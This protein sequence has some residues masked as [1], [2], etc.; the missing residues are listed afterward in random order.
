MIHIWTFIIIIWTVFVTIIMGTLAILASF[1]DS[2]GNTS[3]SIARAWARSILAVSRIKVT[4]DGFSNIDP[5][6]SYI[7]MSNHQ[8]N[9]DI[10]VLL[11]YL[12]VQFRWLA[13]AELF[14]IPLFGRAMQGAGYISIDRSNRRLAIE[15]LKEAGKSIQKGSSVMIFPEGTRSID[16]NIREFKKGGFIL[17][18]EAGVPIIPVIIH[19]TWSIMPKKRIWIKPG[20]VLLE[21]QKPIETTHYSRKTKDDL[22]EDVRTIICEAFTK[23]KQE[24][25]QC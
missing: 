25:S 7:F 11:A 3:H 9:F 14:K 13:K 21:I 15:S 1:L 18:I 24:E 10:P 6:K 4:V 20:N 22:I 23:N 19:G 12:K 8:S 17:A 5:H 2:K 16:G